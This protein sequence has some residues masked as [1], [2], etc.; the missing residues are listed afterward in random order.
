MIS[1]LTQEQWNILDGMRSNLGLAADLAQAKISL[2]LPLDRSRQLYSSA[3]GN[4]GKQK[5]KAGSAGD[6][7][8]LSVFD[9]AEPLTRSENTEPEEITRAADEPLITQALEE[10][11]IT[12][13]FLEVSA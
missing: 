10:N 12:E 1:Q 5:A 11:T 8:F 13:G 6:I 4:T 7:C 2:I 9:Q 3:A